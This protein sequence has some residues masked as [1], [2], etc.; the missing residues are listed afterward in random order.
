MVASFPSDDLAPIEETMTEIKRNWNVMLQ[1][2]CNPIMVALEMLQGSNPAH[3]YNSFLRLHSELEESMAIIVE[4]K[5]PSLILQTKDD[6]I[7]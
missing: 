2:Q 3:D 5:E 7:L 1:E 6:P 4:S